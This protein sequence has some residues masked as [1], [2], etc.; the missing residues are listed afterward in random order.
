MR[1]STSR[2]FAVIGFV[3]LFAT[4]AIAKSQSCPTVKVKE[5]VLKGS[6]DAKV[7]AYKGIPYAQPPVGALRWKAP[8]PPAPWTGTKL[9]TEFSPS[10]IQDLQRERLPWTKPFMTQNDMSEDC[11]YLNVWTPISS[12]IGKF[13]VYL[14]IHGGGNTEGSGEISVYDGH[15]LA[16]H[17]V[18]VVNLNYRLGFL[19]FLAHPELTAE[20]PHHASGNYGILDQIAALR[21]IQENIAQFGGDPSRVTISGQSGGSADVHLLSA[22]P[23]AK[24]LFTGAIAESGSSV[25]TSP[26]TT[27]AQAEQA[28]MEVAKKLGA[29]SLAELRKVPASAFV[30]GGPAGKPGTLI[31]DGYVLPEDVQTIFAEGRENQVHWITGM[32]ADEGSSQPTYGKIPADEFRKQVE[33]RYG[34]MAKR[35]L[36]LYPAEIPDSQKQSAR[37]RGMVSMYLWATATAKT[38]KFPIYT[39]YF[40]E[41]TPWPEHPEFAAFHTSEIAF[42]LDNLD[43][44]NHP[45]GSK[46]HDVSKTMSQY[47]VNFFTNGDPNGKGVPAW[48]P[49]DPN[50][51]ETEEIGVNPGMRSLMSP[52]KLAYWKDYFNSPISKNTGVF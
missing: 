33:A 32:Q 41:P 45:Y 37:D 26:S 35:F 36:E 52:E 46:D 1:N 5:G 34:E 48:R 40:S 43:K 28:G 25:P 14:F 12:S 8:Q 42:D 38:N 21:W 24:G 22:S 39:Y 7:A 9:A 19:G 44:A 17:G 30:P 23:L 13:P 31:T 47:W 3:T 16:T 4:A 6:C 20:S 18:V 29:S 27:L 10:C 11:L 51:P 15:N 49:F 2:F 50:A